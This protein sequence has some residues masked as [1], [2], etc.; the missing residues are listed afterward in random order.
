MMVVKQ[1]GV[2]KNVCF[3]ILNIMQRIMIIKIEISPDK[4]PQRVLDYFYMKCLDLN[5][6]GEIDSFKVEIEGTDL[7]KGRHQ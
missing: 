7:K 5:I 3:T 4:E 2:L 6:L 1:P